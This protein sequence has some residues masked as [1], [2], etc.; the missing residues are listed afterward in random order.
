M[1]QRFL[2][3]T[4][5][6]VRAGGGRGGSGADLRCDAGGKLPVDD[7]AKRGGGEHGETPGFNRMERADAEV[8]TSAP[9]R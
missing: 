4:H 7:E 3:L 8:T 2:T 5:L 1:S 6:L 9:F